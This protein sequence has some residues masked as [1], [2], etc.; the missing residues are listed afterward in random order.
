MATFPTPL[1]IEREVTARRVRAFTWTPVRSDAA[2]VGAAEAD[3]ETAATASSG[4]GGFFGFLTGCGNFCGREL[5]GSCERN[6]GN[7]T[8]CCKTACSCCESCTGVIKPITNCCTGC[9]KG[10][11]QCGLLC[12]PGGS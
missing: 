9:C 4:G 3:D 10:C 8:G 7:C 2:S 12:C 11:D 5:A 1:T 6:I